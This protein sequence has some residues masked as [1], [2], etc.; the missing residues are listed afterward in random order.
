MRCHY[1]GIFVNHELSG[2]AISQFL[3][4]N[5]LQSF[6]N[7]DKKYKAAIRNFIFKNFN[8]HILFIGNNMLTGQNAF[9]LSKK[10]SDSEAAKIIIQATE[11]L[12]LRLKEA[13]KI[14]H[15][16]TYKDFSAPQV[17]KLEPSFKDYYKFSIHPNMVFEVDE[18][19][20]SFDDYVGA[21]NKKY[22]DQYK[23]AVKRA[24]GI[25]RR[26]MDLDDI[27]KHE[28]IIYALYFHVANNAP[29]NTFL[30][31]KNHFRSMKVELG[32]NF[33]FY[34]YFEGET[35]IG[36]NTLIKNNHALETYFLGYD[37]DLQREKMLYLNM[38][39]DMVS[40]AI[41]KNFKKII[42]ART[43]LEIKSSI[44][45]VPVNMYGFLKHR[46]PLLQRKMASLFNYFEPKVIWKQRN[47]F[48]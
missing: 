18:N 29:F 3:D 17:Q 27:I 15:I 33:K 36:F 5:Q 48:K 8:S 43:A 37:S 21:L 16:T 32:E 39:Y 4:L 13:G 35:M 10:I 41:K 30:L 9:Y 20:K 45:A 42:F 31:A 44:G 12:K 28:E 22:R 38:L 24:Q 7:R 1:I 47:P 34:G 2:V 26:K 14:V 40:Y 46:N 23:R 11:E 19:W 25:V 6:G